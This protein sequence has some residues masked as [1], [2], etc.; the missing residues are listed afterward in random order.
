ML[1]WSTGNETEPVVK[2]Q[3]GNY[4][5]H[6][7]TRR[8]ENILPLNNSEGLLYSV[9]GLWA[10]NAKRMPGYHHTEA[11]ADDNFQALVRLVQ[12]CTK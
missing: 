10:Q 12:G 11:S 9:T 1:D 4:S 2:I 5:D 7:G 8:G 6:S 3:W